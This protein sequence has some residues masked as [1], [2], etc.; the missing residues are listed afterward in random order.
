MVIIKSKLVSL[1]AW[2]ERTGTTDE[3]IARLLGVTQSQISR[4]INCKHPIPI[5]Q[6]VKLSLITG[7][8]VDE[9][10]CDDR[11]K[12]LLKLLREQA[13]LTDAEPEATP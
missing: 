7:V 5:D 11:G 9:L 10:L 2:K 13:G 12:K 4:Y 6:A 3:D 8:A 1:Q